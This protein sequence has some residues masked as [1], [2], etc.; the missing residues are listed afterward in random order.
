MSAHL[1]L[2]AARAK[3]AWNRRPVVRAAD[4][5]A[6]L[7]PRDPRQASDQHGSLHHI[8]EQ[9]RGAAAP[10]R[11]RHGGATLLGRMLQH[12]HAALVKAD[13]VEGGLADVDRRDGGRRFRLVGAHRRL[14]EFLLT[15]PS[16]RR[17]L[18]PVS[19]AGPPIADMARTKPRQSF[20]FV[21]RPLRRTAAKPTSG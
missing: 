14:L 7:D 11:V 17:S 2:G 15:L 16:R 9:P 4:P 8:F 6:T 13:G 12:D 18:E 5:K 19:T 20:A 1:T 21:A 3:F 10:G